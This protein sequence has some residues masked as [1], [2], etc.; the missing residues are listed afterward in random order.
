MFAVEVVLVLWQ[1]VF[2]IYYDVFGV[3]EMPSVGTQ[4]WFAVN[5]LMAIIIRI[6]STFL[7]SMLTASSCRGIVYLSQKLIDD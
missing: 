1:W 3:L 7:V 4:V 5:I 2:V 6:Y